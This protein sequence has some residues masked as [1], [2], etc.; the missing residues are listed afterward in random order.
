MCCGFSLK[1]KLDWW[2]EK[3]GYIKAVIPAEHFSERADDTR[4]EL[5]DDVPEGHVLAALVDPDAPTFK[6]LT[7][8]ATEAEE[9][10][11]HHPRMPWMIKTKQIRLS[12]E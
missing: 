12:A 7:R 5:W 11:F 1:E 9:A 2:V 4:K 3:K 10:K 8:A 6:V